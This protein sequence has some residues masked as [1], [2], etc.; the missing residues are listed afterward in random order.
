ME[1]FV[2]IVNAVTAKDRYILYTLSQGTLGWEV[3]MT[4]T[5]HTGLVNLANGE[6]VATTS[7]LRQLTFGH[8]VLCPRVPSRGTTGG[9]PEKGTGLLWEH[10][11]AALTRL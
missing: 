6:V 11:V 5:H 4:R 8:R 7:S 10:C 1:D 2:A 3:D 9:T